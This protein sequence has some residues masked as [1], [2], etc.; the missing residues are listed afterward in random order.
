MV[1]LY[2]GGNKQENLKFAFLHVFEIKKAVPC[3]EVFSQLLTAKE[4]K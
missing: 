2:M 3:H 4:D 1:T